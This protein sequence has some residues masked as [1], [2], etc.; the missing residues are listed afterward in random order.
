M[1]RI[2]VVYLAICLSL[3]GQTAHIG[4][5]GTKAFLTL[6]VVG[7]GTWADPKR[8]AFVKESGVPFRYTLSDD[9]TMAIVVVAPRNRAEMAKLESLAKNEPRAKVFRP[10]RDKQ[11]DVIAAF[12]AL[13]KD[14]DPA[15]FTRP[16][17]PDTVPGK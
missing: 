16:G 6:P 9:G 12:K 14:F 4:G 10:E 11:S 7:S 15:T 5:S 17:P 13:K 8:P 3:L 2:P 1:N